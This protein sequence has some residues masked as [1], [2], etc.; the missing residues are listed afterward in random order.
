MITL[1]VIAAG[2]ALVGLTAVA[3]ERYKKWIALA[4]VV[5][6]IAFVVLA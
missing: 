4:G 2:L 3:G 6:I 1:K 5:G